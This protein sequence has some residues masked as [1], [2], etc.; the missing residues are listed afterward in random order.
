MVRY[1]LWFGWRDGPTW[2]V[3]VVPVVFYAVAI[4]AVGWLSRG[5]VRPFLAALL[6]VNLVS[7]VAFACYAA[8]GID[9]LQE[10][11]IGA[12]RAVA[13]Q[14]DGKTVVIRFNHDAWADVTGF[15]VQ[16]ERTGV[17]PAYRIRPGPS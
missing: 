9:Y 6:A 2:T 5:A 16:A 7:T 11:Y 13:A 1:A 14:A 10:Y 4:A 8:V 17:R 12:V 15:L 3:A